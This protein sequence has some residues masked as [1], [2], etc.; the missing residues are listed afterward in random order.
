MSVGTIIREYELIRQ[1]GE[2]AVGRV[3]YAERQ[4]GVREKRA[5]KLIPGERQSGPWQNEISKV[6][7]L[8]KCR[9]VVRYHDHG[10]ERIDDEE[11]LWISWDFIDGQ[12]VSSLIERKEMTPPLLVSVI[13]RVLEILHACSVVD[14]QHGDLHAGN[15]MVENP[16]TLSIDTTTREVWVTDFGSC[17][18]SLGFDVLD[19]YLGLAT[20]VREALASMESEYHSFEGPDKFIYRQLKRVYL[21]FLLETNVTEGEY[22]RNA[23]KLIELLKKECYE[24]PATTGGESVRHIADYLAAEHIGDRFGEWKE[25]F[26]PDY[27]KSSEALS[28]NV[29]VVTG[30]RGCGKTMLFRRLTAIFDVRLGPS[31]VPLSDTFI[32]HYLNARALAEAFPW[33]P[34]DL[35]TEASNQIIHY[36]HLS[37]SIELVDWL[38]L[39][40]KKHDTTYEWLYEFFSEALGAEILT[41]ST[42]S[43]DSLRTFLSKNLRSSR[44]GAKYQPAWSLCEISFLED[45]TQ[46]I[47]S[48]TPWVPDL[49][50]FFFLDDYSTPLI[51]SSMQKI[52]NAVVFRRSANVIF[53][54]STESAESFVPIGL[55]EKVLE[56]N[57]DYSLIDYGLAVL[58]AEPKKNQ[59]VLSSIISKRINRDDRLTDRGL[60]LK[61]LLGESKDSN[62]SLAEKLK[63]S[64]KTRIEY[65]GIYFFTAMWSSDIREMIRI[66]AGMVSLEDSDRLAVNSD[67]GIITPKIQNRVMREAGSK[68]LS[69]LES[70]TSPTA[71]VHQM[72]GRDKSYGDHLVKIAKAFQQIADYEL[73]NKTSKNDGV[74]KPKQAR[75]IEITEVTSEP[76][77]VVDDY[78]K[79]IIRYG[80]FIRDS[81]G[82]SAAGKAVPRLYL[83][84]LLIPYFTL[85]FSKRDSVTM[86][87]DQFCS[88]MENP[89]DLSKEWLKGSFDKKKKIN[90]SGNQGQFE[91]ER[92]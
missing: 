36:F 79:G 64:S 34:D 52:L 55:N 35:K 30:L 26:V 62:T 14:V 61:D 48:N 18:A 9:G 45:L 49:P 68:Y 70:A 42:S 1:C 12:T 56:E 84:G 54:V 8:E 59:Q 28:K 22:V 66:F 29:S 78:Y 67:E 82:K 6:V 38:S 47:K 50:F 31:S 4:G 13:E 10:V 88:L 46:L 44:L 25:L 83:R 87:W 75:R 39:E 74:E 17:T 90:K 77:E 27:I 37:W 51:T 40:S 81:R 80:L 15:I 43:L 71:K 19:D 33:L 63:G 73:Q 92:E 72:I 23:R 60:T 11:F 89:E 3:F 57:D 20:M 53:K 16:S 2:G 69:L 21:G 5:I 91:W 86:N 65:A 32:G 41:V 24:L 7:A 58:Q 76:N 85:S